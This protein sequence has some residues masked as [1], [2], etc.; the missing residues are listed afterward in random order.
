M[1]QRLLV[2]SPVHN[3]G[4]HIERVVR[5]VAAQRRPP[6]RWVIVDDSSSDDTLEILRRLEGELDFMTVLQ[7]PERT[8]G[9][10]DRLIEAVEVHA[11]N[12]GL[13]SVEADSFT[14]VAKLDGDIELPSEWYE[15][16]LGRLAA[17][18]ALGIAGGQLRETVDG[19]ERIIP[20]PQHH[21]HG[22]LKLYSSECFRAIGGLQPR[23]GWDT[24][25]EAYARMAGFQT[26]SFADPVAIHHRPLASRDGVLR[27][28][29]R[30]GT[31]AYITHQ[32]LPWVAARAVKVGSARPVGLGGAAFLYG[33]L[34]AAARGTERVPDPALRRFVR[35]ELRNRVRRALVP[36]GLGGTGR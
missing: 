17:D 2:V 32:S 28:R 29:A 36:A 26:C 13:Q 15:S 3:E 12:H 24:I 22:A 7:A 16:L 19:A 9:G 10:E 21:V 30:H 8:V 35:G 1:A 18:P 34:Q 6:D 5:A 31:C 14:H 23:L 25:D 11:F 27:G 20:I 33:Y 4:R